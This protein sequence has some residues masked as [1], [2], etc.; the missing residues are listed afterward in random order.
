[1]LTASGLNLTVDR[2]SARYLDM[3]AEARP[4]TDEELGRSGLAG[5]AAQARARQAGDTL[6]CLTGRVDPDDLGI[7]MSLRSGYPSI[8]AGLFGPQDQQVA[9]VGLR[10]I[11]ARDAAEFAH[12][13]DEVWA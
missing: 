13:W 3:L 4:H 9:E 2:G 8:L 11:V 6:I 5:V 1:M 12:M 10:M 7:L